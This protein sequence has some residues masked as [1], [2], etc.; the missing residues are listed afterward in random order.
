MK[1]VKVIEKDPMNYEKELKKVINAEGVVSYDIWPVHAS[2]ST[3]IR[4]II[5]LDIEDKIPEEKK[6]KFFAKKDKA[7]NITG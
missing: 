7:A 6:K 4:T 5:V 1:D 3:Q 2:D